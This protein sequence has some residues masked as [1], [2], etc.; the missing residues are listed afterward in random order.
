MSE[1]IPAEAVE[2][3][4]M[5]LF[6][7]D[8]FNQSRE[9]SVADWEYFHAEGTFQMRTDNYKT[10]AAHVLANGYGKVGV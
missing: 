5:E 9:A 3:L 7:G 10:M 4:A 6:I 1:V 8:N 2:D